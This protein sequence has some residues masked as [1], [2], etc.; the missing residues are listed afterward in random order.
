MISFH[1]RFIPRA[2]WQSSSRSRHSSSEKN[3]LDIHVTFEFFPSFFPSRLHL[4]LVSPAKKM[5]RP[6]THSNVFDRCLFKCVIR[7]CVAK[8]RWGGERDATKQPAS[9]QLFTRQ[10]FWNW[11]N[12][13]WMLGWLMRMDGAQWCR[14]CRKYSS[15]KLEL[16]RKTFQFEQIQVPSTFSSIIACSLRDGRV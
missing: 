1:F 8:F 2:Y 12:F 13:I 11:N 9:E 7:I 4:H 5:F 14:R 6:I 3:Y 10:L 15:R 16:S